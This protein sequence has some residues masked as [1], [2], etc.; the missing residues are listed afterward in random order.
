MYK[1]SKRN[2]KTYSEQ[3]RCNKKK[4]EKTEKRIVFIFWT[5]YKQINKQ[6]KK[7]NVWCYHHKEFTLGTEI[8]SI[9]KKRI[10]DSVGYVTIIVHVKLLAKKIVSKQEKIS[11]VVFILLEI[12][13]TVN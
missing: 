3:R 11:D 5:K 6:I 10:I 8:L 13:T 4:N 1:K 12:T 2:L 9:V 7:E